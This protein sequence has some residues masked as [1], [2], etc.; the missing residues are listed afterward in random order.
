MENLA[1]ITALLEETIAQLMA[2]TDTLTAEKGILLA[3]QWIDPLQSSENTRPIAEEIKKLKALLQ[4]QP[5]NEANITSQMNQIAGKVAVLAP[6]MGTEGEMP[7]LLA[8]LASA[9]RMSGEVAD[10]QKQ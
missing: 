4:E 3:D 8:A 6:D 2:G 5:V 9:L 10:N 7:S 1:D